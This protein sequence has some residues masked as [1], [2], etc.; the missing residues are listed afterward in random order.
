MRMD[1]LPYADQRIKPTTIR[2][3]G[4]GVGVSTKRGNLGGA[5]G[6]GRVVVRREPPNEG[7]NQTKRGVEELAIR[8]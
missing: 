4:C 7:M 5:C 2:S 6:A 3:F 8:P 1:T